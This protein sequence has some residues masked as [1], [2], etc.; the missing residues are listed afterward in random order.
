MSIHKLVRLADKFEGKIRKQAQRTGMDAAPSK[1][2][3]S[4]K[5]AEGGSSSGDPRL[6]RSNPSLSLSFK[7]ALSILD[8]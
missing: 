4:A 6:K 3:V 5:L 1:G 2:A 7:K 8:Q